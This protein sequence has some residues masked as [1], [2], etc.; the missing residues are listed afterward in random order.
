MRIWSQYRQILRVHGYTKGHR[1]QSRSNQS[2]NG[3]IC[4]KLQKGATTPHRLSGG[5]M[6]LH[7]QI[8]IQIKALLSHI[9]KS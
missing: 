4:P 7:S 8:Y 1:G 5:A 9:E 2:C 6:T 3:N